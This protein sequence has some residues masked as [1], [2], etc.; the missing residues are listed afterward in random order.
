MKTLSQITT[1]YKLKCL[2]SGLFLSD[3]TPHFETISI[4]YQA[5]RALDFPTH[6]AAAK[7]QKLVTSLYGSFDWQPVRVAA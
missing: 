5:G 6:D 2:A 4:T 1:G 7:A 3:A